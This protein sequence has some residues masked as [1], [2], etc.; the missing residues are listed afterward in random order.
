MLL[1]LFGQQVIFSHFVFCSSTTISFSP[2]LSHSNFHSLTPTMKLTAINVLSVASLP[3]IVLAHAHHPFHHRRQAVSGSS[4][5]S[6]SL[7]PSSTSTLSA[8]TPSS[9]TPVSGSSVS[10]S[11]LSGT[12]LPTPT[13]TPSFTLLSENPTAYPLS[14]IVVNAPSAPTSP[15]PTAA[16]PGSTPSNIPNAPGI[17][18][19]THLTSF[20]QEKK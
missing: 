14:S 5:T 18:N 19:S 12:L 7:S 8:G 15:M 6:S 10:G 3:A 20:A 2:L 17:P 16:P 11:S 1:Y 4:A 9:G 13:Y